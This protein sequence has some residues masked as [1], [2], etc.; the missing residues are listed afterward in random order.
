M[1]RGFLRDTARD[2]AKHLAKGSHT[3]TRTREETNQ[4]IIQFKIP[5]VTKFSSPLSKGGMNRRMGWRGAA[6]EHAS[7]AVAAAQRQVG[8]SGS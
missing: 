3:N 6:E 2:A 7:A 1:I 4:G 8:C 5:T